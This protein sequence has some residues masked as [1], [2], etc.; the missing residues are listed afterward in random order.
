MDEPR[1]SSNTSVVTV[2][3]I[4]LNPNSAEMNLPLPPSHLQTILDASLTFNSAYSTMRVAALKRYLCCFTEEKNYGI[5]SISRSGIS[6]RSRKNVTTAQALYLL[7]RE[8]HSI[9]SEKF[10]LAVLRLPHPEYQLTWQTEDLF[11][12]ETYMG[13]CMSCKVGKHP[14]YAY[15]LAPGARSR[16]HP[17][18]TSSVQN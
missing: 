2:M 12:P 6:S 16:Y 3:V 9:L 5:F 8:Q 4:E 1:R 14:Q 10:L 13:Q 15:S 11:P 7:T 18:D 17:M